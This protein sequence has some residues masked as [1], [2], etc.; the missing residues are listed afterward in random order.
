MV[1]RVLLGRC[2]VVFNA[3]N[4]LLLRGSEWLLGHCW[5]IEKFRVFYVLLLRGGS[6]WLLGGMESYELFLM[7]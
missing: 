7:H 5:G 3:L 2:K 6:E 4:L 1:T